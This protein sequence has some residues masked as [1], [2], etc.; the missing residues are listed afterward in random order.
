MGPGD[1]YDQS[2][3]P[4]SD[5]PRLATPAQDR[6]LAS[7]MMMMGR[8]SALG[9]RIQRHTRFAQLAGAAGAASSRKQKGGRQ[10]RRRAQEEPAPPRRRPFL[11]TRLIRWVKNSDDNK[12]NKMAVVFDRMIPSEA[13]SFG[14][15]MTKRVARKI[16]LYRNTAT[17]S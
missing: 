17:S 11:P 12:E 3:S 14:S 16:R 13:P 9:K 5:Q 15:K 6:Q 8:I 4:I 1:S 2:P 10:R 7:M